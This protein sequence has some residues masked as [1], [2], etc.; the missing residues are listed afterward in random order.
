MKLNKSIRG[1]EIFA[2][3]TWTRTFE[4]CRKFRG[5]I[6]NLRISG[7]TVKSLAELPAHGNSVSAGRLRLPTCSVFRGTAAIRAWT[8]VRCCGFDGIIAVTGFYVPN[9][10]W[11]SGCDWYCLG[12]VNLKNLSSRCVERDSLR[13]QNWSYFISGKQVM[14]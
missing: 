7:A 12:N 1:Y 2:L 10:C 3:N 6:A 5:G 8:L 13:Y 11:C 4:A 9:A 14:L